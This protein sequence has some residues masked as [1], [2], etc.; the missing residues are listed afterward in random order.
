MYLSLLL[1]WELLLV[2]VDIF[3]QNEIKMYGE[4]YIDQVNEV[5]WQKFY[6]NDVLMIFF[7]GV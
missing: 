7:D 4:G 6:D 2:V 3:D 5:E 1:L